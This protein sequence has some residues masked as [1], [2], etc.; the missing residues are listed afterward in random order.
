[1]YPYIFLEPQRTQSAND[2]VLMHDSSGRS[3][4]MGGSKEEMI[5]RTWFTRVYPDRVKEYER[6]AKDIS[7]SMFQS[8]TGCCG[9]VMTRNG[10]HCRVET[11][12]SSIEAIHK[13]EESAIYRSTLGRILE[14]G[15]LFGEQ[16][17]QVEE[18]HL[19]WFR[20]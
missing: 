15:F 4:N 1:M 6:F 16:Q 2:S 14:T 19:V 17:I 3:F 9:V 8:Q 18:A 7:L 12:W 13:F 20:Q 5:A 10:D 11:F